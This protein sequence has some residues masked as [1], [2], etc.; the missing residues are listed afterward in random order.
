MTNK[1]LLSSDTLSGYWLDH[2]FEVAKE[3]WFDWLDIALWKNFDGWNT[4][5]VKSLVE[6]HQFPIEV[7]QVS[8]SVNAKELQQALDLADAVGCKKIVINPP[9]IFNMSSYRLITQTL[10]TVKKNRPD[11][12]FSI[13]NPK[14]STLFLLPIPQFRFANLE[15]IITKYHCQLAIDVCHFDG[16]IVESDFMK[17]ISSY[18]DK[19]DILYLSDKKFKKLDHIPLEQWELKL[20][21][22][23]KKLK[24][25]QYN[26]YLS[27]KYELEKKTL[28]DG[29]E[30][31][32]LFEKAIKFISQY[33]R[34]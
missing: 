7:I 24:T 9:T 2:I 26:W 10:W 15:D 30:I 5:Y 31:E 4:K 19:I 21:L 23:L 8:S 32:I 11:F 16:D 13:V 1:I 28:A 29:D 20:W 27:V 25:T 33:V 22:L 3:N 17:R 6:K 12:S 14:P 18:K 34:E